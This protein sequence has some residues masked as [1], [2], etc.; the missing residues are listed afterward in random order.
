MI[1]PSRFFP[2]PETAPDNAFQ[3]EADESTGDLIST[4]AAEEFDRAVEALRHAG[5]RVHVFD[6]TAE[7][8]KPDAVFPNNWFS[9]HP[10]GRVAL[11]PMYTP[12]RRTE[13][14]LDLIDRLRE[15]HRITEVIDYSDFE[16]RDLFL[17][18]TGSLVLDHVERLAYVSLSRRADR[19]PLEKF[20]AD[21]D[22]EPVTFQSAAVD[23]QAIYHTNV[24][25][26]LGTEFVLIGL[27]SITNRQEREKV[28][29]RLEGS[30]RTI[31]ELSR[32]QIE[33]F[34]GNALELRGAEEKLLVLSARAVTHLTVAQCATV[35]RFAHLLPLDLPTIELAGGS[36][37]CML[38][39]IHLPPR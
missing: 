3:Q 6:D 25:M 30:G 17:E 13:R 8:P 14:R 28:R 23:G 38:A 2:N 20:C 36:A 34:A 9:T 22:F 35:E 16:E 29:T 26:C 24:M 12:S 39:E 7:P 27:D 10:D 32:R 21:F 37:R 31:V 4:R 15:S 19:E 5:V 18:G 33:N 11:Y 1:R